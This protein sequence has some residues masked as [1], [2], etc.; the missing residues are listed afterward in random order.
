[1][2][3]MRSSV[4]ALLLCA[5]V[6]VSCDVNLRQLLTS[7]AQEAAESAGTSLDSSHF[8]LTYEDNNCKEEDAGKPQEKVDC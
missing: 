1:M 4:L 5:I 3:D 7:L 2:L 8:C 6:N